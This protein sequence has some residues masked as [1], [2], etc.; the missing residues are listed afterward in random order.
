M[1]K[2]KVPKKGS[3]RKL[4]KKLKKLGKKKPPLKL[5]NKIKRTSR[6]NKNI[7]TKADIIRIGI[8]VL[9]LVYI[10]VFVG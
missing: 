3:G 7:F 9:M 6:L 8:S 1:N 2:N 5:V 4:A 10:M